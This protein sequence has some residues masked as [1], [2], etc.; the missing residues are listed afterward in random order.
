[1]PRS[2]LAAARFPLKGS[3]NKGLHLAAV[4]QFAVNGDAAPINCK[5]AGYSI[6]HYGV[7][8]Y[9]ITLDKRYS[10]ILPRAGISQFSAGNDTAF[11]VP[12][13]ITP[14]TATVGASF[15]IV[16]QSSDGT[17]ADLAAGPLVWFEVWG[18]EK[19]S[20]TVTATHV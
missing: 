8:L 9:T 7:G 1:M 20:P 17:A 16:T 2:K 19:P 10:E 15:D 11:V 12:A 3:P 6:H 18:T 5:G 13:S 14:G 4:G